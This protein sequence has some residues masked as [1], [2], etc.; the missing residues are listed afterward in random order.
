MVA[1]VVSEDNGIEDGLK[2]LKVLRFN[3]VGAFEGDAVGVVG[4]LFYIDDCGDGSAFKVGVEEAVVKIV[5]NGEAFYAFEAAVDGIGSVAVFGEADIHGEAAIANGAKDH[6]END[7][8]AENEH[9]GGRAAED[10]AKAAFGNGEH[11][12]ELRVLIHR[13]HLNC[14][15]AICYERTIGKWF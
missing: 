11:G 5:V 2:D 1:A 3:D 6:N 13:K 14:G 8:K 4:A 10:G 15:K 12:A 7:G 9:D